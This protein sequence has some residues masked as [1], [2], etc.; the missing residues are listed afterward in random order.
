VSL[1]G[2]A[3]KAELETLV[4]ELASTSLDFSRPLWDFRLVD[5]YAGGSALVIR[6]HHCYADGI[7]LIQVLLSLTHETAEGSLEL[8]PEPAEELPRARPT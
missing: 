1:P 7:A 5:N 6:I 4:S 3:G 8:P 2:A